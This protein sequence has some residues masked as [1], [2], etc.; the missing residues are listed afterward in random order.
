MNYGPNNIQ[1]GLNA[2]L[3][4]STEGFAESAGQK[5]AQKAMKEAV[6]AYE[7][8]LGIYKPTLLERLKGMF[9]KK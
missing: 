7:K 1:Q 6:S 5:D 9:I 4:N 3:Y 8:E 2:K